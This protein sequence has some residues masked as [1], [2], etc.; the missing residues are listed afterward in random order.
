MLAEAAPRLLLASASPRR[1]DLLQ[2]AGFRFEVCETAT[3]EIAL[4][5]ED[6]VSLAL[7]LARA[8]A[9][10][11]FAAQGGPGVLSLGADTVVAAAGGELLGKPEDDR[12]AER[13]LQL[14]SGGT[15]QVVTGVCVC[16]RARTEAAAALTYVTF[17]TLSAE[18]IRGYVASGESRGKAGAYAI[19][20]R[21]ARFIPSIH[22]DYTN[23]VGLPLA[24]TTTILAAFGV[25]PC[26]EIGE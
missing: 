20:G 3:R 9:E 22:G 8:K 7:R 26:A 25:E 14:L 6:A 24:L 23:V 12:D 4:P 10:A 15:H 21:A 5:G 18:E 17:H 1:R 2:Q 16:G 11:A 13:M 19:Q